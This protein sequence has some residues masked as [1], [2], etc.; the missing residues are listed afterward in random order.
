M[1]QGLAVFKSAFS[2][3]SSAAER[4]SEIESV[5]TKQFTNGRELV[6][7]LVDNM[8][9]KDPR[10]QGLGSS[11]KNSLGDGISKLADFDAKFSFAMDQGI[12]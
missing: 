7:N 4:Y 8:I 12:T 6:A 3:M 9:T 5:A 10:Y 2:S 1:K 11:N